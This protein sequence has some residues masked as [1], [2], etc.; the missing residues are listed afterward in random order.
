MADISKI[1]SNNFY[2][3]FPIDFQ[4]LV[5]KKMMVGHRPRNPIKYGFPFLIKTPYMMCLENEKLTVNLT[6]VDMDRFKE[7]HIWLCDSIIMCFLR[8]M[9][10][11]S[12]KIAVVDSLSHNSLIWDKKLKQNVQNKWGDTPTSSIHKSINSYNLIIFP[13]CE[14][15]HWYAFM[16][17]R[18]V[19]RNYILIQFDSMRKKPLTEECKELIKWFESSND[20]NKY[21]LKVSVFFPTD[22][23]K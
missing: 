5:L 16:F 19:D 17:I 18:L 11:Q 14:N 13:F 7:P 10:L 2:G 9:S 3:V 6:H 12:K 1:H 20:C 15:Y 4:P 22:I 8:W 23:S 21:S